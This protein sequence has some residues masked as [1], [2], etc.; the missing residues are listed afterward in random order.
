M[1][2][3]SITELAD[4]IRRAPTPT[5]PKRMAEFS[6]LR[7]LAFT[8][9]LS[10]VFCYD[11]IC[12]LDRGPDPPDYCLTNATTKIGVEVTS[13]TTGRLQVFRRE[14]LNPA[15]YT[16][17]LRSKKPHARFRSELRAYRLSD[18]S[19]AIPHFENVEDL[20]RDYYEIALKILS[21][22]LACLAKYDS[23]YEKNILLVQDQLSEFK[24]C[25]ERR[26]PVLRKMLKSIPPKA[27]FDTIVLVDGNHHSGAMAFKL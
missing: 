24:S 6:A 16:S 7:S 21:A 20:D 10:K 3:N 8:Q 14:R 2:A 22:K 13:F 25:F 11:G 15:S 27:Y 5:G 26:L 23:K 9:L 4:Q 1:T 12:R 18:D 17:M 19:E